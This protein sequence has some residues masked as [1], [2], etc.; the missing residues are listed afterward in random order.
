MISC[1][2]CEAYLL[3]L[4]HQT[5]P[6]HFWS[7]Q[8]LYQPKQISAEIKNGCD[9]VGNGGAISTFNVTDRL[10]LVIGSFRKCPIKFLLIP[11]YCF[12]IIFVSVSRSLRD[13]LEARYATGCISQ[14]KGG[15][16]YLINTYTV[17]DNCA[18]TLKVVLINICPIICLFRI[19][20]LHPHHTHCTLAF[21]F[22]LFSSIPP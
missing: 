20:Y 1:C 16:Y 19:L 14:Q 11:K 15:N 9:K 5:L 21:E 8:P 12:D 22:D 10:V 7:P 17:I 6:L 4:Q 13:W 2:L 18:C 3:S